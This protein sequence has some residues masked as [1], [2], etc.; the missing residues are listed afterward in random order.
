MITLKERTITVHIDDSLCG[1][2]TTKAC[3]DACRTYGR[4]ILILKEGKPAVTLSPAEAARAGT[5]CLA[6]EYECFFRGR[7]ALE[8]DAPMPDLEEFKRSLN[9]GGDGKRGF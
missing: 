9:A 6:C 7:H 2:C 4:G 8:I 5:E 3:V 1:D